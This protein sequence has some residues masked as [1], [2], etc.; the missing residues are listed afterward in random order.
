MS[1]GG[2]GISCQ[3]GEYFLPVPSNVVN[4]HSVVCSVFVPFASF[5]Q[6]KCLY[7][8]SNSED[9]VDRAKAFIAVER[10]KMIAG[11][12]SLGLKLYD[13]RANYIFFRS[14]IKLDEALLKKGIMVRN[15][16]N[17]EGVFQ[18]E[19]NERYYYRIAVRTANENQYLIE[20][21]TE[22]LL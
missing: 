5:L 1:T 21:L 13:S 17:Y 6:A 4:R 10:E 2:S 20:R 19:I 22:I 12:L 8:F 9:Y 14:R 15:C 11:L 7:C 18:S 3:N 16:S